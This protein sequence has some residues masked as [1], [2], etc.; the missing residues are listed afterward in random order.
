MLL[1]GANLHRTLT[2]IRSSQRFV[3]LGYP[4]KCS[5][6]SSVEIASAWCRKESDETCVRANNKLPLDFFYRR[7]PS[8]IHTS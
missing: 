8:D 2:Q 7:S 4:G 5:L 1:A 6:N 3:S